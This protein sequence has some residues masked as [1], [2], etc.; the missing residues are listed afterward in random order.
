MTK[1]SSTTLAFVVSLA[2]ACDEFTCADYATCEQ[3]DSGEGRFE[4]HNVSYRYH[5]KQ[6]GQRRGRHRT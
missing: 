3:P 2:Q 4:R 6:F 5:N 1:H